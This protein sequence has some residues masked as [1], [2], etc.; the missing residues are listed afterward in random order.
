MQNIIND[1]TYLLDFTFLPSD[2]IC[3]VPADI[4]ILLDGSDSIAHEDWIKQKHF[5]ASLINNLDVGREM[6]HVSVAVFSTIIGE[7]IGLTPFKTKE[8]LM[9]L[10]NNLKQPKVGTNTARGI[11]HMRQTMASQGRTSA[12]KVMIIVTDGK[13]SSPK[14]TMEQARLAKSEG[15]T[16]IAVGVGTQLFREELRQ[17]ATNERKLFT[18]SDFHAL[19]QIIVALRNLICQGKSF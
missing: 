10:T 19:Q 3:K 7:T 6:I 8:L 2:L 13:S 18:V 14:K 4:G 12:P 11:E 9:I 16:V 15:I 17:I 1:I 5:V